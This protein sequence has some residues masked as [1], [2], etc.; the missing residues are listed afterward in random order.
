MRENMHPIPQWPSPFDLNVPNSTTG[1][2]QVP[3]PKEYFKSVLSWA[4]EKGG[5]EYAFVSLSDCP[6]DQDRR[7]LLD[8]Y[9]ISENSELPAEISLSYLLPPL[10]YGNQ[11]CIWTTSEDSIVEHYYHIVEKIEELEL[12]L[13]HF[14][15]EENFFI[16]QLVWMEEG[17]ETSVLLASKL[18]EKKERGKRISSPL[19][20]G[21]IFF[22]ASL[23]DAESVTELELKSFGTSELNSSLFQFIYMRAVSKYGSLLSIL[24]KTSGEGTLKF[25]PSSYLSF[26][27]QLVILASIFVEAIDELVSLW[28]EERPKA[29]DAVSKLAEWIQKESQIPHSQEEGIDI[30]FQER[31]I[32]LIDKYGDRT[33]RFLSKRLDWEYSDWKKRIESFSEKRKKEIEEALVPDLLS[34]IGAHS[35]VSL[36][37][38]LKKASEEIGKSLQNDLENLLLE[39]NKLTE[40]K[41]DPNGKSPESW[42]DLL[43]KRSE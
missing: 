3:D 26:A 13:S 24:G 17:T 33:D 25:H 23:A 21:Q 31:T 29:K 40:F 1:S 9:R 16:P 4:E 37:D 34:R 15:E 38:E 6:L 18:W 27:L 32:R 30:L 12:Q 36:P 7:K 28:I 35:Q 10:L 41:L 22:L 5:E 2:S 14:L 42:N 19:S 39:R 43:S 11:V 8:S 20:F